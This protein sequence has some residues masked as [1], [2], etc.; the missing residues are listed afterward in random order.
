MHYA[1]L[2]NSERLQELLRLLLL[3]PHTTLQILEQTE[4]VAAVS[5]AISEL[6]KNGIAV[7]CKCLRRGVFEYSLSDG[8][9]EFDL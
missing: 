8:Q 5:P 4:H 7:R 9:S 1:K 6:R 2:E 3:G